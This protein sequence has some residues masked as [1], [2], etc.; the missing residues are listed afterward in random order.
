MGTDG[1]SHDVEIG[2]AL[3]IVIGLKIDAFVEQGSGTIAVVIGGSGRF[4]IRLIYSGCDWRDWSRLLP[5]TIGFGC[6]DAISGADDG[7][8][9]PPRP[10]LIDQIGIAIFEQGSP[11]RIRAPGFI[12][13]HAKDVGSRLTGAASKQEERRRRWVLATLTTKRSIASPSG[14]S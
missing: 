11:A 14:S 2:G 5:G 9:R 4:R 6:G 1:L 10:P 13:E 3:A 7:G 8:F 12:I